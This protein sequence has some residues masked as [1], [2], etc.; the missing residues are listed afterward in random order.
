METSFFK[1]AQKY[2]RENYR[3]NL[4]CKR[5][6]KSGKEVVLPVIQGLQIVQEGACIHC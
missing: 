5:I 4:H 1:V 3:N 2:Q 6:V